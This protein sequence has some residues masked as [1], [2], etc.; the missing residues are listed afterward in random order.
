MRLFLKTLVLAV[1]LVAGGLGGAQAQDLTDEQMKS[2]SEFALNNT[3][4]V[5]YHELGH[6]LI[7]QLEL[8]VLGKEED[9]VDNI[10]TYALLV[11]QTDEADQAL[12]DASYG[13]YLSDLNSGDTIDAA[14][15]ADEHSLDLQRAFS[16]VCLM[17]GNDPVKF[18]P[19]ANEVEMDPDRQA[20]C[21]N[22]YAQVE[23]SI[24]ALLAPYVGQDKAISVT[25]DDGGEA[26]GWAE[27]M[28]RDSGILE[29]AAQDIGTSFKLPNPITIRAT[30]CD[31]VNAFYSPDTLEVTVCYELL[32]DYLNT[33][34][35]DMLSPDKGTGN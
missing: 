22:D 29:A 28:L 32:E 9:A 15:F 1:S 25:Y 33:I 3:R 12:L 14:A 6:M 20:S 21:A 13:W 7:N 26:Y 4:F 10:A 34:A 30:T 27:Q 11:Q 35:A 2:A 8:P 16:I 24:A 17:V 31:E 23:G 19:A 18:G 5:L